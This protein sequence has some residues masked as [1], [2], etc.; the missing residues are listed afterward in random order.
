MLAKQ[1]GFCTFSLAKGYD[2]PLLLS[3]VGY[4]NPMMAKMGFRTANI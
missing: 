1:H 3:R 4:H 2:T